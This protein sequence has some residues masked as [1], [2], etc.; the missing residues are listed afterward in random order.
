MKKCFIKLMACVVL[1]GYVSIGF[2]KGPKNV[3]FMIG[4]G[5]GLG[6]IYAAM[7][8]N[9][10]SLNIERCTHAGFSKTYSADNYITDSAAGGTALACGVKTKNGMVGM[11][12][13]SLPVKSVLAESAEKGKATGLVVTCS[14]THATPA[15]FV[16]HQDNRSKDEDIAAD[17]LKCPPD[18]FIGGGMKYFSKRSDRQDLL[19]QLEAKGYVVAQSMD[20]LRMV[21]SGK[22]AG[23]L[24]RNQPKKVSDGREYDLTEAV[25]RT[26]EILKSDNDGFF[27]MVEGSQIDWGGHANND[28]YTISETLDFDKAVGAVLD[29][30]EKDGNTLVIITADHETGGVTV[31]D[32][33][34]SE[35][36]VEVRF[37][38]LKHTGVMVPIFSFGPG[39][40]NF[41][42]VMQNTDIPKKIRELSGL[43]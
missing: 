12:S 21:S 28:S 10:G 9:G 15:S 23:L 18:V 2:A 14:V 35:K 41:T 8:S 6:T 7:T 43:K 37:N 11:S 33:D 39:S 30:A 25:V 3:I 42:G 4:D 5:M 40:E 38:T 19:S 26:I 24:C 20:E 27:L 13:D 22:L 29:F 17:F 34:F 16:A 36:S 31:M 1:S 32:G